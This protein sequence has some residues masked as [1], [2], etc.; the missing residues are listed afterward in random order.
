MSRHRTLLRRHRAGKTIS[1]YSEIHNAKSLT[2]FLS[3]LGLC[4]VY[5]FQCLCH[6]FWCRLVWDSIPWAANRERRKQLIAC[7]QMRT[8]VVYPLWGTYPWEGRV[9]R[10]QTHTLLLRQS[11]LLCC[12]AQYVY[13]DRPVIV[14]VLSEGPSWT[15]THILYILVYCTIPVFGVPVCTCVV[16]L[17]LDVWLPQLFPN[18]VLGTTRGAHLDVCPNTTQLVQSLMT[19]WLFESV[20]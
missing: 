17:C 14:I 10:S 13:Y 7:V 9:S 2:A 20:V 12:L 18:L 6:C 1:C 8:I 16:Y 19:S 15:E 4:T 3:Y 11:W 5:I